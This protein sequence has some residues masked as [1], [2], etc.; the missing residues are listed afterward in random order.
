MLEKNPVAASLSDA[1]SVADFK[2]DSL[3]LMKKVEAVEQVTTKDAMLQMM[4]SL[5][6]EGYPS[7]VAIEPMIVERKVYPMLSPSIEYSLEIKD[8][9]R[10]GVR[11]VRNPYT[12]WL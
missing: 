1:Y 9:V 5:I 2:D 11:S 12:T 7:P 3:R 10:M 6:K 8:M 4:A